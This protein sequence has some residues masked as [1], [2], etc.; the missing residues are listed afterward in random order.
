LVDSK[1][2]NLV[3]FGTYMNVGDSE[4]KGKSIGLYTQSID[5]SG[6]LVKEVFNSYATEISKVIPMNQKGKIEDFGFLYIHE[7]IQTE[8]GKIFLIGE[9]F[10]KVASAM[11][12]AATLLGSTSSSVVNVSI[13]DLAIIEFSPDFK[14][15]SFKIYEKTSSKL[16]LPAGA[17]MLNAQMLGKFVDIMG[18]FDYAFTQRLNNNKSFSVGYLNRDK[19]EG[20]KKKS[21][22]GAL[23]YNN[24]TFTE[25]K[26]SLENEATSTSCSPAKPGYVMISEYYRKLKKIELRLE[27]YVD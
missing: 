13:G 3:L 7:M 17:G 4:K 22:F 5:K 2:G 16:G 21:I 23:N 25:Q 12:I 26:I 19:E 15:N 18:G 1:T 11:G 9:Q 24:G 27:K 6:K 20:G 10:K 8:D 14:I